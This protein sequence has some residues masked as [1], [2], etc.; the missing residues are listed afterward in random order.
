MRYI[1][2]KLS[3]LKWEKLNC[4]ENR[5]INIPLETWLNE[6]VIIHLVEIVLVLCAH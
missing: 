2:K 1:S 5:D 6:L 3:L 4:V